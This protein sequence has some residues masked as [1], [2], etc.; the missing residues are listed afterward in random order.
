MNTKH[1]YVLFITKSLLKV[2]FTIFIGI[3]C[4]LIESL[5]HI[6]TFTL[7]QKIIDEVFV[8]GNFHLLNTIVFTYLACTAIHI[9]F[10]VISPQFLQKSSFTLQKVIMDKLLHHLHYIPMSKYR[11]ERVTRY[12]NLV[13]NEVVKT[14]N[15]LAFELPKG[16]QQIVNLI[17]ISIMVMISSPILLV[18]I[19]L[20]SIFYTLIGKKYTLQ[21]KEASKEVHESKT[22][23]LIDIEEGIS[24][25]REIIAFSRTKWKLDLYLLNFKKYFSDVM[26]ET[27]VKNKLMISSEPVQ[28]LIY[29]IILA[30]G[31][32]LT[33]KGE[34]SLGTYVLVFRISNDLTYSLSQ[35]FNFFMRVSSNMATI[36]ILVKEI[37]S[38]EII[39]GKTKHLSPVK[40]IEFNKVFFNYD[41]KKS[42][43]IINAFD[44]TIP[45]GKK[46]AFIGESGSGK[47]TIAHML[48]KFFEPSSGQILIDQVPLSNIDR[49]RWSETTLLVSQEPYLFPN[50]VLANI[51]LGR[52]DFTQDEINKACIISGIHDV[53]AKL[54]EKY[55]TYI[56][57]R[58]IKLS[59]G[60]RQRLALAR[61][62]LINP[63]I[64]ILDEST[65]ALDLETE[66]QVQRNLDMIRKGKTTIVIA[67]RLSTV[68]NSDII[69]VFDNG[70]IVANG[71]HSELINNYF[72]KK[73][74]NS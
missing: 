71:S 58:G 62:I 40:L 8:L 12:T 55:N 15:F 74:V 38:E 63:E 7:Q 1:F 2:K 36:E 73:L 56:G 4:L 13:T 30:Y 60:Q 28:W 51:T 27:I 49:E 53:I 20:C 54:P 24:A 39:P 17:V 41:G 19:I 9:V 52:T 65:S 31:G 44:I 72:Y 32:W 23:M 22:R 69:Y 50:T 11:N 16:I 6:Y 37:N 26:K 5:S 42:R 61:A 68:M 70:K 25:T 67:H 35:V 59:G 57:E 46:I 47:S 3:I 14:S 10:F 18:V 33:F 34:I 45:S 64:L 21:L 29:L 48:V 43:N 66:R